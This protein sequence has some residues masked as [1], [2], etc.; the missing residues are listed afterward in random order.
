M[1]QVCLAA[2]RAGKDVYLQ[3]PFTMTMEEA[4]MLRGEIVKSG[5]IFQIGS[6]QRS[7][8]P[9]EQFRHA[10][11]FVRGG[12]VGTLTHVE[13]GLPV[14]PSAPDDPEQPVPANLNYDRWLGSTPQAYYTEQRVHPQKNV[15]DRPG[16]LRH[17]AHC[18]GMITGWGAHYLIRRTGGWTWN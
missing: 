17:E 6:Q 15:R 10:V 14:D 18:L 7:W 2:I 4:I 3:K 5:R 11:E 9:N 8:G 16:W 13:I 12:R 1:S